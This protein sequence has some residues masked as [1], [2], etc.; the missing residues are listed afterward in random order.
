MLKKLCLFRLCVKFT[1]LK[2]RL[3]HLTTQAYFLFF[4]LFFP[5]AESGVGYFG[6]LKENACICL[7]IE[8]LMLSKLQI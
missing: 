7:G 1:L 5:K 8:A 3:G 6:L 2:D 4:W